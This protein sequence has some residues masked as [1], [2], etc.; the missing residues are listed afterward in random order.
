MVYQSLYRRFRPQTFSEVIGQDHLVAALRN[1]VVEE[2]VGHAYLLSGPRGTGKTSTARI[3]A[4]ALNCIDPSGDGEPCGSCDS[5][6]NFESGTSMDLVEL[7]AAS[8]NNVANIR[9]ITANAA[10]GSPGK[11]KVYLLDEVHMLT[12]AASNALLK[13]LEEPP[14]HV[15]FVLATTDPQ[16]VLPTIR[17]RTQHVELTL[18]NPELLSLHVAEIAQ[19]AELEI[20]SA[21]I[22]YVVERGS[23]SVRDTLSALDQV[24][25]AGGIPE[26]RGSVDALI[27][28]IVA[29]DLTESMT[30]VAETIAGGVDPKDLAYRTTRKLR[31]IFL[32]GAGIN[33]GEATPEELPELAEKASEI[34]R[35]VNVRALELLGQALVDM[36]QAP[37]QRLVLD[38]ALV[39]LFAGTSD[40]D[41]GQRSVKTVGQTQPTGAGPAAQARAALGSTRSTDEPEVAASVS[42][43]PLVP[44]P[45]P[46]QQIVSADSPDQVPPEIQEPDKASM[47][48]SISQ[49]AEIWQQQV[50]ASLTAR[51]RARF[52][53]AT[54]ISV[55]EGQ[56]RFELPNETHRE[57]CE[58]IKGDIEIAL[59]EILGAEVQ[60]ELTAT[61]EEKVQ[62]NAEPKAAIEEVVVDPAEFEVSSEAG[63]TSVD[64]VLEAFPGAIASDE[65]SNG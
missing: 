18:V 4:K 20:D 48:L 63:T 7:D 17:S 8:N 44:P 39:R 40:L 33:S 55:S 27:N 2:R 12:A 38:L 49:V 65:E 35:A 29:Q 11:R 42:D 46:S 9:E 64:R 26:H 15:I 51:A 1:A 28:A 52:Q 14:D 31:D 34:T 6:A 23:G 3:L 57:R 36:R 13:T 59:R 19:R 53:A 25:T 47:E 30:A 24:V 61:Q 10:L 37:D 32:A 5:C 16:K 60:V 22:E 56:I 45:P 62:T 50:L 41:P 58:Q 43:S 54:I 21:V